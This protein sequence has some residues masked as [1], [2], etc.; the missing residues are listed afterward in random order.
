[1][2]HC[3]HKYTINLL[4]EISGMEP[5]KIAFWIEMTMQIIHTLFDYVFNNPNFDEETG[6]KIS[7]WVHAFDEKLFGGCPA[8]L[9]DVNNQQS[10]LK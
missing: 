6:K 10:K 3:V 8:S 5:H 9:D 7:G 2:A 1:M 4:A